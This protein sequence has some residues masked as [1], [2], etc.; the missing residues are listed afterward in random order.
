[1]TGGATWDLILI[2]KKVAEEGARRCPALW[3]MS[4]EDA[5]QA[6]ASDILRLRGHVMSSDLWPETELRNLGKLQASVSKGIG[7]N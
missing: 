6:L 3:V 1:M 4:E 2:N 5:T 7:A